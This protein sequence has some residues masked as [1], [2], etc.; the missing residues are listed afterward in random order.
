MSID[1]LLFDIAPVAGPMALAAGAGFFLILALGAYIAFRLLR[2]TVKMAIR[3]AVVVA[4]LLIAV[5]GSISIYWFSSGPS[6]RP[7]P[8]PTRPR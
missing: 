2:R 4:I 7:R 1:A 8:V 5:I 6:P 3:M